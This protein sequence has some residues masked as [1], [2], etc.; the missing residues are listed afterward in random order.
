MNIDESV[1]RIPIQDK[2]ITSSINLH[3]TLSNYIVMN[4]DDPT[5]LLQGDIYALNSIQDQE[6]P[7]QI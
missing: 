7:R 2:R 4:I 5:M 1:F 6:I 3:V